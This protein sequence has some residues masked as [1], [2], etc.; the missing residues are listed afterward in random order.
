MKIG[1]EHALCSIPT[2]S[3]QQ[4]ELGQGSSSLLWRLKFSEGRNYFPSPVRSTQKA[5]HIVDTD[6]LSLKCVTY[7]MD[8]FRTYLFLQVS[9]ILGIW[10]APLSSSILRKT[11]QSGWNGLSHSGVSTGIL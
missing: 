11:H 6:T 1:L 4:V 3:T 8:S 5:K 2:L 9:Y 10:R 7:K